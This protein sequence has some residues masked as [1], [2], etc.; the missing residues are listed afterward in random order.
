M[1]EG[2]VGCVVDRHVPCGKS[3]N[4]EGDCDSSD[5]G[6]DVGVSLERCQAAVLVLPMLLLMLVEAAEVVEIPTL[7]LQA[8]KSQQRANMVDLGGTTEQENHSLSHL[9][10]MPF[11]AQT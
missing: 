5:C 2:S 10:G 9:Q 11:P 7:M 6:G 3:C 4:R 8:R 1:I